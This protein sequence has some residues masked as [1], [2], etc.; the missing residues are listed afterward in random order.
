[1][2]L[3]WTFGG[4]GAVLVAALAFWAWT[5]DL[6]RATL[7]ARYLARPSDM[8]EVAGTRLH[9]RDTGP[10][11]APAVVL[12]HGFGA[13]LHTWEPWASAL[14]TTHRVVRFDLPGSGLSEPDATGIYTEARNLELL[15]ALLDRLGIAKA[16][17]VG[18]SVGGRISW[19]FAAGHPDRVTKLVLVSP[20]GFASPGFEYGKPYDASVAIEAMRFVLPAFVL[21]M[22]LAPAYGD[23]AA[24][25]DDLA[26][27][28][29]DLMRAPGARAAMIA[30][31]RQ[32]V[33][34]DP[35]PLLA[36]IAAPVLLVWGE[37]DAMIPV[38]NA[39]DYLRALGN[40]RLVTFPD[41]GHVPHEEAP[42][43]TIVPVA[44]FL[45]E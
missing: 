7:E 16:A 29:H 45:R 9:V 20:D 28:Y 24:M 12:L 41:L 14:E 13:S 43:R 32:T 15:A 34:V 33:L 2:N 39:Q 35:A 36:R 44:A 3:W 18:N 25:T 42:E 38:T 5:P 22:S 31:L 21:R 27:R 19:R 1:M 8:I 4:V 10:R 40:A 26:R 37:K 6:P 30:R 11:E 23:P 17:L